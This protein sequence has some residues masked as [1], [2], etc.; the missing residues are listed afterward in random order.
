MAHEPAA[1]LYFSEEVREKVKMG[2]AQVVAWDSIKHDPPA[3]LKISPVAAI[4]HNSKPYQWILDLL[5]HLRLADGGVISSVN[6]MT[7]KTAPQGAI[8]QIRHLLK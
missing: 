7:Q 8:G 6:K 1:L 5:F 4:P 3:Q 2:Q